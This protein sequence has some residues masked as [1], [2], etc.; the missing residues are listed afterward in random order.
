MAETVTRIGM[1]ESRDKDKAL[2]LTRKF[3][4]GRTQSLDKF[5]IGRLPMVNQGWMRSL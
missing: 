4:Q 5:L 2:K 1:L 3:E